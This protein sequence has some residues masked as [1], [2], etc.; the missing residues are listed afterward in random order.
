MREQVHSLDM[1]AA[2]NTA[3]FV[4]LPVIVPAFGPATAGGHGLLTAS[5]SVL[6]EYARDSDPVDPYDALVVRARLARADGLLLCL[7]PTD[8]RPA[9]VDLG[10]HAFAD[11]SLQADF[12]ARAL[13]VDPYD[14]DGANIRDRQPL[15]PTGPALVA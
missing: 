15:A 5:V 9:C 13:V 4:Q 2:Q 3:R 11:A 8:D 12:A 1:P 7:R 10:A 6:G 14:V